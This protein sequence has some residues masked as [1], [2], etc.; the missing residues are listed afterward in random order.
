MQIKDIKQAEAYRSWDEAFAREMVILIRK[1]IEQHVRSKSIVADMVFGSLGIS[2]TAPPSA[3][4]ALFEALF[5]SAS[6]P[7][8]YRVAWRMLETA[9]KASLAHSRTHGFLEANY[10]DNSNLLNTLL[11]KFHIKVDYTES[12]APIFLVGMKRCV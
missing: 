4:F 7:D 6:S 1:S 2:S 12:A 5:Y 3:Y 10:G 11:S 8:G 9:H